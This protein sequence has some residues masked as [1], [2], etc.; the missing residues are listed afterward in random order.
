VATPLIAPYNPYAPPA[1]NGMP[2]ASPAGYQ[3]QSYDYVYDVTLAANQ[4]LQDEVAVANDADFVLRAIVVNVNTGNFSIQ[5]SD[6]QWYQLSNAPV[7]NGNIQGDP[8]SPYPV[9]NELVFPAGGR[10]A[11]LITD[12]SAAPNTIQILFRGVKRY[13][14]AQTSA[15]R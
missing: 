7:L 3:D 5:I 8:S 6:A 12:I 15:Q 4:R 13:R 2:D 11:I 1:Y 9:F 10:I 14:V